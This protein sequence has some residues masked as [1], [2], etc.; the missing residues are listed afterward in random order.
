MIQVKVKIVAVGDPPAFPEM[1]NGYESPCE[2]FAI[3]EQGTASGKTSC[4]VI[5]K[6]KD[7]TP[8]MVQFTGDMFLTM[9]AAL[10]GA[11]QRFGDPWHGA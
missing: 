1:V 7:G 10:K 9:A 4:A 3:L 11:R 6:D 2:V 5:T 8:I